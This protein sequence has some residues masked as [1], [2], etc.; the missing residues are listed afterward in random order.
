MWH[1]HRRHTQPDASTHTQW[2]WINIQCE[3]MRWFFGSLICN[4]S[5]ES[6]DLAICCSVIESK[7]MFSIA[8]KICL[9]ETVHGPEYQCTCVWQSYVATYYT[10]GNLFNGDASK[11]AI[12][13]AWL[14]LLI[15]MVG[16]MG[17]VQR[18]RVILELSK[19]AEQ[20][21]VHFPIK[22][23][24]WQGCVL[25]PFLLIVLDFLM[26]SVD[27]LTSWSDAGVSMAIIFGDLSSGSPSF[28]E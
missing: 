5:V 20:V 19:H 4:K 14:Q 7:R 9:S 12:W 8:N 18:S 2:W 6:L 22:T 15:R 1:E 10:Y 13:E 11:G 21:G 3:C 17:G 28:G 26:R 25:S 23:G 16:S 24:V 27:Q